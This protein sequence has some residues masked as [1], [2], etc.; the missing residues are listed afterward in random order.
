MNSK[1][2]FGLIIGLLL[3]LGLGTWW[4]WNSR[5]PTACT[6]DAMQCPDGSY[7]GRVP[8][9][10]EF[11]P[12]EGVSGT[13]TGRVEVGPLCPVEPCEADPID[14][15]SRQV[16]LESSLGREILVSLYADGTFYPTK[17]APGTY[18]ATL[19]DCVWLGCE[20]ELPKTVIVTKDQTTE[21]LIEIDT[22][23]R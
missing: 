9:K 2:I 3:L 20:S 16:I 4:L 12:C 19:T 15:S 13:V 1:A 6:A 22:G 23:I 11:A 14:F 5:Q 10:C 21:I 18:Q 7:V 8:P 17:V